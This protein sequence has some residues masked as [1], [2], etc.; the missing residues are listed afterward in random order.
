GGDGAAARLDG[1]ADRLSEDLV[2]AT[3]P[4]DERVGSFEHGAVHTSATEPFEVGDRGLR[5]GENDEVGPAERGGR[6]HV[7]HVH[8]GLDGERVEIGEVREPREA[9]DG[10]V[11]P[12]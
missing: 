9:H 6:L 3:D 2:T 10:D 11:E 12:V 8:A 1:I 5:P 7:A 4:E